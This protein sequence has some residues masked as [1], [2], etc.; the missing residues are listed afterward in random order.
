MK[1][2]ETVRKSGDRAEEKQ[3]K[4]MKKAQERATKVVL[5]FR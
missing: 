1:K 5:A 2:G 4:T 3:I